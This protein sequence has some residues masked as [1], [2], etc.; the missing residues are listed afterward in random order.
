MGTTTSTPESVLVIG[1][2][3]K[4]IRPHVQQRFG[5]ELDSSDYR[6]YRRGR[7]SLMVFGVSQN[8]LS[9]SSMIENLN[10]AHKPGFDKVYVY[11][12]GPDNREDI[13]NEDLE[14]VPWTVPDSEVIVI[15][16]EDVL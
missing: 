10:R 11:E 2:N 15:P 6:L 14:S 1:F 4:R 13:L 3:L 12:I 9:G 16:P 7:L 5:I 8:T